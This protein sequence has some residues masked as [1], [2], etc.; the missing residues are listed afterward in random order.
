MLTQE[1]V[2]LETRVHMSTVDPHIAG[3]TASLQ[4]IV[5][6][7][8]DRS[9][10]RNLKQLRGTVYGHLVLT[11]LSGNGLTYTPTP[12]LLSVVNSVHGYIRHL[13]TS[14]FKV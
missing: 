1:F 5:S 6:E 3:L 10:T 9:L 4:S 11:K 13:G 14:Q 12:H 2:Q 8:R 7:S